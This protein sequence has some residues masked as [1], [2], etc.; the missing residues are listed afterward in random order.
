MPDEARVAIPQGPLVDGKLAP[1]V[2][3]VAVRLVLQVLHL[4]SVVQAEGR[5]AFVDF[6]GPPL[7][8]LDCWGGDE[9]AAGLILAGSLRAS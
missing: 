9:A 1:S 7:F 2:V 5:R 3:L 6:L 4:L 8:S